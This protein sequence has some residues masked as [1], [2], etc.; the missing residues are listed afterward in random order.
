MPRGFKTI[1]HVI[2]CQQHQGNLSNCYQIRITKINKPLHLHF[3]YWQQL[4]RSTVTSVFPFWPF[5]I[6]T[7]ICHS[8]CSSKKKST[9]SEMF[10]FYVIVFTIARDP[11]NSLDL[12]ARQMCVYVHVHSR[13]RRLFQIV[14]R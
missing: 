8:C 6:S 1:R 10:L 13:F 9:K 11:F 7:G 14:R 12:F 2:K 4:R 5:L 3:R